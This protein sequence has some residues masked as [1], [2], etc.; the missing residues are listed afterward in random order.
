ML[1]FF[2][3]TICKNRKK[4]I[5]RDGSLIVRVYRLKCNKSWRLRLESELQWRHSE[6]RVPTK[7]HWGVCAWADW[8][9]MLEICLLLTSAK[10]IDFQSWV[11]ALSQGSVDAVSTSVTGG[12]SEL[13][14]QKHRHPTVTPCCTFGPKGIS[15]MRPRDQESILLICVH[16]TKTTIVLMWV[17]VTEK[18]IV[19]IL[20]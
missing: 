16:M 8:R 6:T 15:V 13:S 3:S 12:H 2:L 14:T 18:S 5:P 17:H 7:K 10:N 11:A 19:L 1:I 9:V 4:N 20:F